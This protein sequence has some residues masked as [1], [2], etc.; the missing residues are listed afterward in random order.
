MAN[1]LTD[2]RH[3]SAPTL[4]FVLVPPCLPGVPAADASMSHARDLR[5]WAGRKTSEFR[6]TYTQEDPAHSVRPGD[7]E[8][9]RGSNNKSCPFGNCGSVCLGG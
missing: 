2:E 3:K 5:D 6:E 9:F 7:F 4:L 8:E 1:V